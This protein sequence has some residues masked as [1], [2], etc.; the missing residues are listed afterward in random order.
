MF[1]SSNKSKTLLDIEWQVEFDELEG[2]SVLAA[3]I[4]WDDALF[5]S[6]R[7][8]ITSLQATMQQVQ[9]QKLELLLQY[10]WF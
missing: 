4:A 6:W 5:C 2:S 9:S 1:P 10:S 7:K 8:A 3:T